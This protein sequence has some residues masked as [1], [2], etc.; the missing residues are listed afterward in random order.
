M[1][2]GPNL[3]G[4]DMS[5]LKRL[6]VALVLIVGAVI[7]GGFV[8]PSSTNVERSV[9]IARPPAEVFAVLNSYRRFNEWS[10]WHGRDPRT[11]YS[12]EGPE[13]GLGAGMRWSSEQ[14]D[15]GKGRQTII[16]SVPNEKV[17]TRLEFEGQGDAIATFT[18]TAEGDGTRI[19]W[20]FDTDHG[21][22]PISR[23]FGLMLDR[24][25]GGD[26]AQGLAKL[27]TVMESG[28]DGY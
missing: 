11:E 1:T 17:A 7:A 12:F 18:L 13:T 21:K 19:V 9:V 8:L 14:S 5:F 2:P 3:R 24:W 25:V 27:K 4:G 28:K 15:V 10:P 26:F 20:A 16:E 23:W 6:L 22:N